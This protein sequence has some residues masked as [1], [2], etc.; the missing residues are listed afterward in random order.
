MNQPQQPGLPST[1]GDQLSS[2]TPPS[3]PDFDQARHG[4][5]VGVRFGMPL[6][7]ACAITWRAK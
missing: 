1:A 5:Q 7:A 4:G 2:T 6:P 3:R